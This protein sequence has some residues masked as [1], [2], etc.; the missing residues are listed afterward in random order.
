M[1]TIPLMQDRV[2]LVDE[3]DYNYLMQWKW[4]P[5]VSG[6]KTKV[7]ARRNRRLVNSVYERPQDGD[8]SF[9][10]HKIIAWRMGLL[11][12]QIDHY[13]GNGLDNRRANLRAATP[14]QNGA[15]R[16]PQ[17]N[18]TSGFKGVYWSVWASKWMASIRVNRK[19]IYLGYFDSPRD[20][21]RVYNEAALKHFGKF[22]CLNR[23]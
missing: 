20:A 11:T 15:N 8:G 9:R 16:G 14:S 2:A 21:A 10:M 18:N 17:V 19:L 13:N 22:A 7:Y 4:F 1:K 6:S 3:C 12:N 23:V 5:V